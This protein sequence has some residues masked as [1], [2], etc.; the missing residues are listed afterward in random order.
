MEN[1]KN[2]PVDEAKILSSL[3]EIRPGMVISMALS[4]NEHCEMTLLAFG[5][6]EGVSEEEYL[7]DTIYYVLE[8]SMPVKINEDII[9]INK[10][11]CLAVEANTIHAI[12]GE[13][14]FKLLQITVK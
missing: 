3:I 11:E 10:G 7:G 9:M 1:L 4:K 13:G 14:P 6:G 2:L 8:G 12:G 5:D